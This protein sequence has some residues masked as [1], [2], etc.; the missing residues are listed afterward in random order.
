M[1]NKYIIANNVNYNERDLVDYLATLGL[2]PAKIRHYDYWYLS[3]FRKEQTPSFKV[4]RKLNL[5]Y[6]FGMGKGG[7][8]LVFAAQ[9]KNCTIATYIKNEPENYSQSANQ[10]SKPIPETYSQKSSIK[11]TVVKP[12]QSIAL[13][14]YLNTRAIPFSIA[15]KYCIEIHYETNEKKYFSIGFKNDSD[16][17]EMRNAYCKN[18]SS[19]KDITTIKNNTH[20]IAI[21]EGFFD[22][23]SFLFLLPDQQHFDWDF[24]ILNSLFFSKK[25]LLF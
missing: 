24:C 12:L 1:N 5:W 19:P 9:F 18:S 6:D 16:G 25:S 4:N 7:N 13:L 10:L 20:K 3:P 17:Y 15:E 14:Q 23:L 8:F 2:E 21:F 22:F 11:I